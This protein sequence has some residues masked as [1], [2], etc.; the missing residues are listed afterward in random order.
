MHTGL[1]KKISSGLDAALSNLPREREKKMYISS[2]DVTLEDVRDL[3]H[4]AFS[5]L[6]DFHEVSSTAEDSYWPLP[7]DAL[8]DFVRLRNQ[9]STG[10]H[11]VMTTKKEDGYGYTNRMEND[12]HLY[13]SESLYSDLVVQ[14]AVVHGRP[15]HTVTKRHYTLLLDKESGLGT[16]VCCY[17][18]DGDYDPNRTF[19]E[20]E[21]SSSAE[22]YL[23]RGLVLAEAKARGWAVHPCDKSIFKLFCSSK[24]RS[25]YLG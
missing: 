6:V 2:P 21:G 16:S 24:E 25:G 19:I 18:I 8:A 9:D 11:V 13:G 14:F 3:M 7:A 1:P 5:P 20:V 23:A 4:V 12:I 10:K 15:P 22:L 17:E